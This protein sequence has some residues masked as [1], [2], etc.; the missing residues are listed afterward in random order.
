V[1]QPEIRNAHLGPVA[2]GLA[3]LT[4][5]LWGGTAVG[6]KMGLVGMPPVAMAA[7]RFLLGALV[8]LAGALVSRVT[9]RVSWQHGCRLAA[10]SLLFSTQIV[11]L[12]VGISHTL[13]ARATVL[14][15]TY[16]LFIALFA[17]F[18]IPGDRL[19][20]SKSIG[21]S[22]SFGGVVLIFWDAVFVAESRYLLGDLLTLTSGI[23]LGLRQVVLKKLVA[24][25]HPYTVLFWQAILSLPVFAGI[26]LLTETSEAWAFSWPVLGA[27]L[28][29]GLV[30]AGFCFIVNVSLMRRHSA[31]LLGAFGFAT[32]LFGVLLS[33]VLLGEEI[34]PGLL[35]SLVLVALGIVAVN[36]RQKQSGDSSA[37]SA[38]GAI[39]QS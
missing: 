21:L 3:L 16:P 36:R 25:L 18:L 5:A 2:A 10:L 29:L 4:A 8:M 39:S 38:N 7:A 11:L 19:T 17:H 23:L 35:F 9:L 33:G 13:A 32:P 31:S 20:V 27:V 28:Y 14:T 30:V 6:I 37:R 34:S 26:S 1:D 22:L 15:C 12:N 24:G